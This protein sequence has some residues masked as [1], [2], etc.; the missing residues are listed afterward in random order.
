MDFLKYFQK[1]NTLVIDDSEIQISSFTLKE[2]RELQQTSNFRPNFNHDKKFRLFIPSNVEELL[3]YSDLPIQLVV[4]K[5]GTI[6]LGNTYIGDNTQLFNEEDK[7]IIINPEYKGMAYQEIINHFPKGYSLSEIR[8][9][10]K[11][12]EKIGK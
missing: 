7:P 3:L 6:P 1:L 2:F 4:E 8:A 5:P 11:A 10:M 9:N 12:Y